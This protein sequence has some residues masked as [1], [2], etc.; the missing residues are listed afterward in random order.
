MHSGKLVNLSLKSSDP[1]TGV[2][3][4]RIDLKKTI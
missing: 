3:F 2:I 4:K 1:D